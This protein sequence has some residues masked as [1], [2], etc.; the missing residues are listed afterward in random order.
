MGN[1]ESSTT[2]TRG[3]L[4]RDY[5]REYRERNRERLAEQKREWSRAKYERD[6][7]EILARNRAWDEAN[8]DVRREISRRHNATPQAREARADRAYR[9]KYGITLAEFRSLVD[10]QDGLCAAC[11][12]R[13]REEWA[14]RFVLD[15]CHD[16]GAIRGAL[17]RKCNLIAGLTGDD[18]SALEALA[19]YLR[20]AATR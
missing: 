20:S 2:P 16:T 9:R 10:S 3:E 6:R 7:D 17:H 5:Q 14:G 15:H 8:P 12:E 11:G 18:P 19:R 1:V 4:R 13:E